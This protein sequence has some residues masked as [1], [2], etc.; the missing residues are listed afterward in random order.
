MGSARQ[1]PSEEDQG[2]PS[3]VVGDSGEA[4][5]LLIGEQKRRECPYVG[6]E[7]A[8]ERQGVWNDGPTA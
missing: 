7:A 5:Q 1:T 6:G 8:G 4:W 3:V 2:R